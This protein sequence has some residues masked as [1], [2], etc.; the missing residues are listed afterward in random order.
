MHFRDVYKAACLCVVNAEAEHGKE[1]DQYRRAVAGMQD[2]NAF[3]CL[4]CTG[5]GWTN[6]NFGG[7]PQQLK[8]SKDNQSCPYC[9]GSGFAADEG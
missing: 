1:S 9:L 4:R 6:P 8:N 2:I 3:R 7:H 5:F